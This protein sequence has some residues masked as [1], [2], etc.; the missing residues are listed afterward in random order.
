MPDKAILS[1]SGGLDTSVAIK[2]LEE[3]YNLKVI[4]LIV[5]ID[6]VAGLEAVREKALRVGAIKARSWTPKQPSLRRL[7]F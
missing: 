1:Y 7:F 6:N 3:K 5:D 2:W 4:T